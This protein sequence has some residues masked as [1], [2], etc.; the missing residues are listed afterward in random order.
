MV[1][2]CHIGQHSSRAMINSLLK[3]AVI[4]VCSVVQKVLRLMIGEE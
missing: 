1:G 4:E 3:F 2:G